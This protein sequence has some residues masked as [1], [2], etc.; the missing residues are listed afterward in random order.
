MPEAACLFRFLCHMQGLRCF[1]LYLSRILLG[2]LIAIVYGATYSD[3]GKDFTGGQARLAVFAIVIAFMPLLALTSLPVY[4]NSVMVRGA[5]AAVLQTAMMT[6]L[7]CAVGSAFL[8]R[9]CRAS[10]HISLPSQ[11]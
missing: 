10:P 8:H 3:L 9:S 11:A 1:P 5:T 7:Y 6:R 4:H 2:V